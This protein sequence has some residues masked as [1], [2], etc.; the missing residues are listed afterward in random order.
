MNDP[1]TAPFVD[2]AA[3]DRVIVSGDDALTYLQSQIAQEIRDQAVGESRWT[4]VL[5]P[6]GKVDALARIARTR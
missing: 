5:E 1:S 4:L 3:R 2:D 6:T